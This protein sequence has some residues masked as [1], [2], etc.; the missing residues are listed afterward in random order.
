MRKE[1]RSRVSSGSFRACNSPRDSQTCEREPGDGRSAASKVLVKL[2]SYYRLV[3]WRWAKARRTNVRVC[4][5]RMDHAEGEN[6]RRPMDR[7][8]R[9]SRR[10]FGDRSALHSRPC[11]SFF[12][13]LILTLPPSSALALPV[14][15]FGKTL[16]GRGVTLRRPRTHLWSFERASYLLP[17]DS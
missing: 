15:L 2:K 9:R 8:G 16:N 4:A 14:G 11:F 17:G 12:F 5:V 1:Q 13:L 3:S 7:A 10:S 6:V